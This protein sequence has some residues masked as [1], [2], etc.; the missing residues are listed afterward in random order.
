VSGGP[1]RLTLVPQCPKVWYSEVMNERREPLNTSVRIPG[2]LS[3]RLKRE[4]TRQDRTP[5]W[6]ILRYIRRGLEQDERRTTE[7]GE[8]Q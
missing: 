4:A 8:D 3:D 2:E 7:E 5:H 6:L 1:W